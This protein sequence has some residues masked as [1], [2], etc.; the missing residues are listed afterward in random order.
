MSK[1]IGSILTIGAAIAVN[2]IPGAGQA[3]SA[4]L[5]GTVG[6]SVG[7]AV[8]VSGAL[9][10]GLT[11]AGA[12]S[13]LS[14]AGSVLGARPASRSSTTES[15]QK[16]PIPPRTRAYGALRLYGDWILYSFKSDGT[17]IDVWA[18][19]DGRADTI[20]QVY[21]NDD[22]VSI[23]GG[24]VQ[25]LSDGRYRDN[26]VLAGYNVGLQ[27]ETAFGP[28][29]AALPGIWTSDHRGDG[30]VTGY[31][32]KQ[33]T[34]SDKFLET[35]PNGDEI[36]M[37]LAAKWTRVYDF[38]LDSTVPG[39][40]GPQRAD[41]PTTWAWDDNVILAFL[42]H[43]LTQGGRDFAA[44]ILPQ[45]DTWWAAADDCDVATP[46]AAGG[47]E[48]RY[49]LALSYKAVETPAAVRAAIMACCDGWFCENERGEL[50]VYSGRVYAP[51]V[52]L[53]SSQIVSYTFQQG[54]AAEDAVNEVPITFV[55]ADHDYATIDAQSW[56]D[57]A[58]I[59][60]SGRLPVSSP[61]EAQIPSPSQGR[62]LAKRKWLRANAPYRG[63]V[64][65]TFGGR[66]V[67]R[68]RYIN[69]H[70]EEGG[71][72][73]F[74]GVAEII[75]TP[76]RDMRSGGVHF[77]WI[78]VSAAMDAWDPAEEE[79]DPA[80]LPDLPTID[81]LTAPVITNADLQTSD[82][83]S[84][85]RVLLTVSAPDRDDLNWGLRWRITT[86]TGWNESSYT[87]ADSGASI[88]LLSP[89]LPS[90]AVID[91]QVQ[92]RTGDGRTSAWSTTFPVST[93]TSAGTVSDFVVSGG[94]G[95]ATA[96]WRNPVF[97]NLASV[98]L[99]AGPTADFD[100]ASQIDSDI[101]A[102]LGATDSY[103]ATPLSSGNYYF[104]MT[105]VTS[106][107]LEGDPVVYGPVTVT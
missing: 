36:Q 55:S 86:D 101:P 6:L 35:Y 41:D 85:S 15:A 40:S 91:F 39:G 64:T 34:K 96:D 93:A 65:T 67:L 59:D 2:V 89:L 53:T 42:H 37:S 29:V 56:R 99:Y 74:D 69:L 51:T 78:A 102:G 46:L 92:Y 81:E 97:L 21:L 62:R 19:H 60:A 72:V 80:G 7:T 43:E 22:K 17:P 100:D 57:Q 27:T 68:Q 107:G 104:F 70:I 82:D 66:A 8:A 73:F 88:D 47:T 105:T 50:S 90:G 77:E 3:I 31:L 58:S 48:P 61:L 10:A 84:S 9:T 63:S 44:H 18:F 79:G 16:S 52:S 20:L 24:V 54:V 12:Q 98:R 76:E 106:V 38:R 87:D 1:A 13:A 94:S 28:V 5:L 103:V 26:R 75:G 49:R 4:F 25:K 83:G 45:I 33:L 11:I 14:L 32:I 23:V 95:S 30:V 71:T